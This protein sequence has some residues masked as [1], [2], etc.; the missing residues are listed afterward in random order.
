MERI[1]A[2]APTGQN[3]EAGTREEIMEEFYLWLGVHELLR[4]P[5]YVTQ[6]HQPTSGT[7]DNGLDPPTSITD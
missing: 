4:L 5:S 2:G 7:I 3:L 1:Q 6:D